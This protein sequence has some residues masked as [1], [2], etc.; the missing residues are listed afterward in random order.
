MSDALSFAFVKQAADFVAAYRAGKLTFADD[1][2]C[3]IVESIQRVFIVVGDALDRANTESAQ[4]AL[5]PVCQWFVGSVLMFVRS[6]AL[7]HSDK[8][9]DEPAPDSPGPSFN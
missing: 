7:I 1:V 2:D 5:E 4:Y 6:G 8:L 9:P 3:L